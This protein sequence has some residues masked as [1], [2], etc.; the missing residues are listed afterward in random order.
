MTKFDKDDLLDEATKRT[1]LTDYGDLA[2]E[3]PL[4]VLLNSLDHEADLTPARREHHRQNIMRV[5]EKRLRL[6]DD[7]KTYPEIAQQEIKAPIFIVG[8]PRTGSTHLHALMALGVGVR[9]PLHWEMMMPSPPPQKETFTT[10]PR[11]A[12]VQAMVAKTSS[13]LM[14]RHPFDAQRP[15]QC[16]GLFDW[17]FMNYSLLSGDGLP[18]YRDWLLN[19]DF[20]DMYEAHRRTLQQL[21]WRN[22]GRWVLKLPKHVFTMDSL[23]R[24]YPDA[25][26]VW[27]HRDP[28]SVLPSAASFVGKIR[29]ASSN[30]DSWRFG[31]EWTSF[32]ELGLHRGLAARDQ[33]GDRLKVCDVHYNDLMRDPSGTVGQ[34]Y[35]FFGHPYDDE[36]RGR[37]AEWMAKNPQT[38]HGMHSY[39]AEQFGLSEA[40]L[41][42]RFAAYI[43]R[44]G[45]EPDA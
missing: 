12:E 37:I 35:S 8:L 2:L 26:I 9:S 30:Y 15:E 13:E 31:L 28:G 21:H 3:E 14:K 43:E 25:G 44:F 5:L 20:A 10:D 36:T 39:T 41:R 6:I 4:G 40:G 32:E 16:W 27:T 22:P 33:L 17:T 24:T 42:R 29:S 38:K 18:T 45:V 19:A 1:G 11:I 34:I 23:I 7:R